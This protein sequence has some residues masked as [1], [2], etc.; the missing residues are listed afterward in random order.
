MDARLLR[1]YEAELRFIREMGG[2]FAREYPKIAGRLGL[3]GLDCADPYVERLLEGFAFLSARIQLKLDAE[4][5]EF[6]R[7]L[8]DIVHPHLNRP[9]PSMAMVQFE[10]DLTEGALAEGFSIRRD[11]ALRAPLP[12]GEK[13]ACEYRTAHDVTLWPLQIAGCRYLSNPGALAAAGLPVPEGARAALQLTL[14]VTAGLGLED[15]ALDRLPV[16]LRGSDELPGVIYEQVHGGVVAV[17]LGSGDGDPVVLGPEAVQ[18]TGFEADQ[19]LL[20][21]SRRTFEGYRLLQ[22]YF[23]FPQRYLYLELTGL[24]SALQGLRGNRLQVTFLLARARSE[25]QH[26]LDVKQFALFTTPA[27]NLFPLTADRIHVGQHLTEFH[28]VPD[29]NRP[30]DFEVYGVTDV[31]GFGQGADDV[32]RFHPFYALSHHL[33][34]QE[35]N[36]FYTVQRRP[37]EP[38]SRQRRHGGRTHYLGSECFVSVVDAACDPAAE[39]IRQLEVKTL[40]TNRDLPIQMAVGRGATD[41]TL[42]TGAPVNAVRVIAGP[43]R[44]RTAL[45]SGETSWRLVSQLSLNYLSLA[46]DDEEGGAPGAPL[47][48]LLAL[49]VDPDDAMARHVDGVTSVSA[50]PA[51]RRIPTEGPI[52]FGKGLE[53]RLRL[54][55]TAF[56][57][58]GAFPLGSVLDRFFAKYVSVNAF[59]Q[60]V[61]ESVQRGEIMRWP[62]RIGSRRTL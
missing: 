17:C 46:E 49:Y 36:A 13:T 61:V 42:D 11:S 4:F 7:H 58:V 6:T 48:E 2:E 8:L 14:E 16:Y 55:E 43:T 53:I 26:G 24:A 41:F 52:C 59:T 23:A 60:T 29:R 27:I 25:L 44:P 54:D 57:G 47:R 9:L 1:F 39:G 22:E 28:V 50:V 15:L 21:P 35:V 5:P 30:M 45:H 10:P 12:K 19:A 32:R 51:V 34:E 20:P 62:V 31:R 38:S 3:E 37:R 18:P 56:A 40:C 33:P